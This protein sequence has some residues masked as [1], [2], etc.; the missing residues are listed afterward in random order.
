MLHCSKN[1][2]I[3]LNNYPYYARIVLVNCHC[4]YYYMYVL[5]ALNKESS[6]RQVEQNSFPSETGTI[7]PE[8]SLTLSAT[9]NPLWSIEQDGFFRVPVWG[10]SFILTY[11][12]RIKSD[13]I[14]ARSMLRSDGGDCAKEEVVACCELLL[15]VWV[16]A[17]STVS[18][19]LI[20]AIT[21]VT[22]RGWV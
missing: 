3:M 6:S 17:P 18:L 16:S 5:W 1:V 22:P 15:A 20:V 9:L 12:F 11:R 10:G 8:N 2:P 19:R 13:C 4:P 7:S 21:P 14:E